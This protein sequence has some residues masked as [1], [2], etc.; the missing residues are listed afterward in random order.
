MSRDTY[1][2][3]LDQI[4]ERDGSERG[5]RLGTLLLVSVGAGFL[6]FGALALARAPKEA[7]APGPDPLGE[8]LAKSQTQ[9][10]LKKPGELPDTITFPG[11]L[12]DSPEPTTALVAMR[13]DGNK[14]SNEDLVAALNLPPGAPTVPPPPTDRLPVVPLPA[15]T[16]AAP[17]PIVTRP[18]DALTQMAT[19]ASA[20]ALEKSEGVAEEGKPGGYQLQASSFRSETEAQAFAK[21]LRQRGHR[22]HVERAEIPNR[23]TWYR[24][25]IGPFR[26]RAEARAYRAEFEQKEQIVPYLV[27]PGK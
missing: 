1:V 15:R 2:R 14:K 16:V 6:V 27:E 26:S 25:R 18:R 13:K 5:L 4:Q 24:V 12:S 8:L 10:D 22:A 3:N 21:A 17:S 7:A 20:S 23:G 19:E 11:I 9:K